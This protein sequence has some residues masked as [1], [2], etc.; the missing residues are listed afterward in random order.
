MPAKIQQ[1]R[2]ICL[3]NVSFKNFTKVATI[4]INSVADHLISPTQTAYKRGR[5]IIEG[6]VILHK[7]VHELHEKTRVG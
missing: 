5:N 6:V 2:P 7:T 3:L 1:Y 4:H